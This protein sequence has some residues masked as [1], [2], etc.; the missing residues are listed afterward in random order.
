MKK[1]GLFTLL[2]CA[3][4]HRPAGQIA[5]DFIGRFDSFRQDVRT[6]FETFRDSTNHAFAEYLSQSWE[7]FNLQASNPVPVKPIP[8]EDLRYDAAN[9]S[10]PLV[11]PVDSFTVPFLQ[12][13]VVFIGTDAQDIDEQPVRNSMKIYYFGTPVELSRFDGFSEIRLLS[14]DESRVSACWLQLSQQPWRPLLRELLSLKNELCLND[15]AFY[16]LLALA[17]D[18]Y[19]PPPA[20]N[21]KALFMVFILN[22]AGYKAKTGRQGKSLFP[23]IAFRSEV[24]GKRYI[25]FADGNYFVIGADNLPAT[26]VYS[27]SLNYDAAIAGMDLAIKIPFRLDMSPKVSRFSFG[28]KDYRV[29]YNANLIALYDTYPQTVLSVYVNAPLSSVTRKSL[30][31][32]L[33]PSLNDKTEEEALAFLLSFVQHAFACKTDKEQFGYEKYFFTEELFH[34]PYSDC[35]DRAVLF[36]Q[37]VRRFIGLDVVLLDYPD[38]VATGVKFRN[39][40]EGDCVMINNER[41]V[42]CDP[43]YIGAPVGRAMAKYRRINARIIALK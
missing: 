17:G 32:E 24:Y 11:L 20:A 22:Q 16:Q 29:E 1:I 8:V 5:D 15:W 2:C 25:T 37:L 26:P 21:E 42:V 19:Y 38:H 13:T 43:A 36:S 4:L 7:V 41:Y 12:E 39:P 31:R 23:L 3:C 27:Y 35:E 10:L 18:A 14:N 28:D 40:V 6:Q 34:Y 30:E 9:D 33:L